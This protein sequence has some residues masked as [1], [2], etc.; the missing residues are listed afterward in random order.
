MTICRTLTALLCTGAMLAQP[1]RAAAATNI[2]EQKQ[3]LSQPQYYTAIQ[4]PYQFDAAG[5]PRA[6][7]I[8]PK[9]VGIIIDHSDYLS[10]GVGC[11]N[12]SARTSSG[13][14]M[15]RIGLKNVTLQYSANNVS[16]SDVAYYGDF[17][18]NNAT[19]FYLYRSFPAVKG[20]GYYRI[21]VTHFAYNNPANP[22]N[23]PAYSNTVKIYY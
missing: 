16:W 15:R 9:A 12:Y 22:Q 3:Y 23:I 10:A 4:G 6:A 11:V 1:V 18:N 2:P 19:S 20:A 13:S 7:A 21:K 8:A 14:V 17:Y 5:N